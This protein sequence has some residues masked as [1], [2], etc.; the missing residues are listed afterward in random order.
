ME[1]MKIVEIRS[2]KKQY[3]DLLLLGDEQE[4]MID[5]YLDRGEMFV[6]TD[7]H[8]HAVAVAVVTNEGDGVLEL[9]NL[10]VSPSC[11]RKGYGRQMIDYLCKH[12]RNVYQIL[13]VGT[14]DSVQTMSF[15]Q[16]CNFIYSHTIPDFF[17]KHYD[18]PII[19]GGRVLKDMIYFKRNL[20]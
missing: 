20:E 18:H 6:M 10:A 1:A 14:G 5:R 13:Q 15:Y 11:Q 12:Y 7:V 19:E 8:E 9:K 16:S 4:S 2:N 17:T 3:L